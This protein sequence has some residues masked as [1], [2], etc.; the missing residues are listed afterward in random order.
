MDQAC[1]GGSRFPSPV[2][3]GLPS[4]YRQVLREHWEILC[5][6]DMALGKS[7][8]LFLKL[9]Y[10]FCCKASYII[11][12]GWQCLLHKAACQW[13]QGVDSKDESG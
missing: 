1:E 9:I 5:D 12:R 3:L 2:L 6:R 10:C 13:S 11:I 4:K 7:L 8:F